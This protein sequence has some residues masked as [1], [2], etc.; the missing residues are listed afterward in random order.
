MCVCGVWCVC[1]CVVCV[2]CQVVCQSLEFQR[3][4]LFPC[5]FWSSEMSV[6]SG[7]LVDWLL[8]VKI[9][10]G[11][12]KKTKLTNFIEAKVNIDVLLRCNI[13]YIGL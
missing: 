8:E 2:Q 13:S 5:E 4:S 1:V 3:F 12:Q 9:S 10:V 11:K 6:A 7:F